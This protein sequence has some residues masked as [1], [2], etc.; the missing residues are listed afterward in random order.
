MTHRRGLGPLLLH[1]KG[2]S[3]EVQSQIGNGG[4]LVCRSRKASVAVGTAAAAGTTIV[5]V[6]AIATTGKTTTAIDVAAVGETVVP[7]GTTMALGVVAV[8][9]GDLL[10]PSLGGGR[11]SLTGLL[12][13]AG[14]ASGA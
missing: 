5:V 12:L 3:G 9:L 8:R 7:T 6:D 13:N 14:L 4:K 10:S 1:S 11:D 2:V